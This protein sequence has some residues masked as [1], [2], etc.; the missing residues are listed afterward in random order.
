MFIGVPSV[1]C[2]LDEAVEDPRQAV[3]HQDQG[4]E[5]EHLFDSELKAVDDSHRERQKRQRQ[6]WA[7][8]VSSV[9]V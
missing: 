5:E 3:F 8:T 9:T 4:A 7:S 2:P 6:G 1:L